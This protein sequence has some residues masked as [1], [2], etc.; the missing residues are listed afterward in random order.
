MTND[1]YRETLQMI[2]DAGYAAPLTAAGFCSYQGDRINWFSLQKDV[3]W[4]FHL[5]PAGSSRCLILT[6]FFGAQPLYFRS[7]LVPLLP[8]TGELGHVLYQG[9][10]RITNPGCLEF[11]P[12]NKV[13]V[14]RAT[15]YGSDSLQTFYFPWFQTVTTPELA[16]EKRWESLQG[17]T[18]EELPY[19]LCPDLV[20]E[21]LWFGAREHYEAAIRATKITL[22]KQQFGENMLS[23]PD[24]SEY[25]K[26]QI[27]KYGKLLP[28]VDELWQQLSAL[29][30]GG[31]R[32]YQKQ[33][34]E[35]A[36]S[37]KESF[38]SLLV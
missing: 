10:Y 9:D 20:D 15:G 14:L 32:E 1:K 7:A 5:L 17:M 2:S 13:Y 24:V 37:F 23:S 26:R 6:L 33:L 30:D 8:Y 19:S 34:Q 4:R 27:R 38:P 25:R 22:A 28:A 21:I 11:V 3:L 31:E 12:L 36:E 18:A 29:R 35:R 16:F